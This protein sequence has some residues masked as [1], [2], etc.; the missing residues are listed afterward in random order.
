MKVRRI[1]LEVISGGRA[2]TISIHPEEE[3]GFIRAGVITEVYDNWR[4][5]TV[6]YYSFE[7]HTIGEDTYHRGQITVSPR[8]RMHVV[9]KN[10]LRWEPAAERPITPS[11][12]E[13]RKNLKSLATTLEGWQ[14]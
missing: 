1:E 14:F 11:P 6:V 12:T 8:V 9:F 5:F 13:A 2:Y 10:S 3:E 7:D 4:G